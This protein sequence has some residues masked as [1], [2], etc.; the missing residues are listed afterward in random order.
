MSNLTVEK[1]DIVQGSAHIINSKLEKKFDKIDYMKTYM[2]FNLAYKHYLKKI[3][4]NDS[5][6]VILNNF[7]SR[8]VEY[9]HDWLNSPKKQY[10]KKSHF[11]SGRDDLPN[12]LCVDIETASICDLACPHCFRDYIMTPDKIMSK[13][14]YEKIISS[15]VKMNVPS[16]KLNWRGEPLLNPKISEFIDYAKKNGVLEVMINTNATK[17]NQATAEK[18]INSGLDQII[19][20]FDGGTKK[21]YDKMRPGRFSQNKFEDVYENIKNFHFLREKMGSKFPTTKIQMVLTKDTR[22][23]IKNFHQLFNEYV[24]DVTVIHYHERGGNMSQLS[25]ENKE[26]IDNYTKKNNLPSDTPFMVSADNQI[27]LS[28]ERKPCPQIFQRLMVTFDGRVGMC[29]HDWGAQHC[30]GVIDKKSLDNDKIINDLEKSIKENKKGFEL[31]QKAEKPK[32]LSKIEPKIRSL[33]EIWDGEE[34]NRVRTIQAQKKAND[35]EVCKRC[36]STD[37][38]EWFKI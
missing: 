26:K 32:N 23:E 2:R 33:E 7:I 25:S 1:Q 35:L 10:L 28:T 15:V 16:I 24:D 11:E 12:P 4:S 14:L 29:C 27:Y 36:I 37:T 20:S 18:L 9:R 13:E 17:L 31:L 19:F 21:T 34:L 22:Q 5:D 6:K 8:Y 38:Y 30:V 3:N